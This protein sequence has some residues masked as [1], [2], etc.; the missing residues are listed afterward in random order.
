MI[1]EIEQFLVKGNYKKVNKICLEIGEMSGVIADALEFAYSICSRGT[2]VEGA[3]LCIRTVP[4]TATCENC[5][6]KFEVQNYCFS[7][8]QCQSTNLK[9]L[10]G[11]ELRIKEIE[12]EDGE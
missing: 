1:P 4:V 9:M 7:C 8:P 11:S 3:E 6:I 2:R 10:S 12:V 5:F